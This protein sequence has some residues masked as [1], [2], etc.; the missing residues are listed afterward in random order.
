MEARNRPVKDWLARVR[1]RQIALPRFQRF[2]AWGS[3]FVSDLLTNVIRGLPIGSALVL[4]VA[5]KPP[6]VCRPLVSA[7]AG[8]DEI[9]ELLLDGQQRL[10]ALWRSLNDNYPDKT[11]LI[12]LPSKDEEEKELSVESVTRW[13]KDGRKYPL[14]VDQPRECWK[15]GYIPIRLLN[16]DNE[17]EYK[18]WAKEASNGNPNIEIEIRDIIADLRAKLANFQF[19]F[20][21][22]EPTTPKHVAINVFVKLNT[23]FVQLRAFDIV[24][25]QVEEAT[26]KSLHELVDQL[27]VTAPGIDRYADPSDLVLSIGALFQDLYPNERGYLGLDF[28]KLVDDWP[29]IVKGMQELVVFLEE[30]AVFDGERLPTEAVLAPIAALWAEAPESPDA[31]GNFRVLLRKYMWRGFFSNRYDRAVPTAI[32]QDYRALK[33]VVR[34][35]APEAEVPCF[36][37]AE[38]PLPDWQALRQARWPRYKD[39]LARAILLLSLRGGAEDIADGARVTANNIR[40]REYHHLFPRAWLADRRVDEDQAYRALNCVLVTWKTNRTLWSKE[41][42]VYLQERCDA[43]KLGKDEIKRRLRTHF[44][45]FDLLAAGDYARFLD[46]RA[47]ACEL[48]MKDLCNGVA[49]RP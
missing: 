17:L 8:G 49:W 24:V 31:K 22:L 14:W 1:T 33:K 45:D 39:R 27:K 43:S 35:E 30:E 10:T 42:L 7:P 3:E 6:F 12:H 18:K 13:E 20:L 44:V 29:R 11:Y 16:P 46:E 48:A 23:R 32:L 38:H 2:E 47:K 28:K 19:P 26:G 5:G 15:R 25:A 9:N 37:E 36:N 4:G 21:Y 41:P 40:Q 34:G